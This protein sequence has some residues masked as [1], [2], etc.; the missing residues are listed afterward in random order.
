[1][2]TRYNGSVVASAVSNLE[3]DEQE[4][5]A[6][7]DT[8]DLLSPSGDKV[9][10]EDLLMEM[11]SRYPDIF[12]KPVAPLGDLLDRVGL[13]SNG[14]WIFDPKAEHLADEGWFDPLRRNIFAQ[15]IYAPATEKRDTD[16]EIAVR[17]L[18]HCQAQ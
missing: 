18:Q 4:A 10:I 17:N 7:S 1:M 11:Y 15:D 9:E 13:E 3:F 14:A 5:R 16:L 8:F 6:L 2:L 12:R